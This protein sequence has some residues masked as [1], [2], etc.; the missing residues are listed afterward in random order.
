[1]DKSIIVKITSSVFIC[2]GLLLAIGIA[3]EAQDEANDVRWEQSDL[4]SRIEQ[5][6]YDVRWEQSDLESRI[7]H[8]EYRVRR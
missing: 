4:E 3:L 7:E 1:M 5:L 2:F 6:E 8:L